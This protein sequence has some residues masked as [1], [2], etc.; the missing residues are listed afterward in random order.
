LCF[1]Y[2]LHCEVNIFT[3]VCYG[4]NALQKGTTALQSASLAGKTN[5]VRLLIE[6]G[7]D[8][9][10]QTLV[11]FWHHISYVLSGIYRKLLF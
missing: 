4:S 5:V 1:S 6:H 10:V 3:L 11:S 8:I 7:A 9:N 2:Q